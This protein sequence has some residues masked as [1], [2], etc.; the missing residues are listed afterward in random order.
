MNVLEPNNKEKTGRSDYCMR[1]APA[2]VAEYAQIAHGT[3]SPPPTRTL[4]PGRMKHDNT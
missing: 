3:Q 1:P 4:H 2:D